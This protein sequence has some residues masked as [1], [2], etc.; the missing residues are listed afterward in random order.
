MQPG[1]VRLP[2]FP[3]HTVLFPG[4]PLPLRIFESRYLEM[5]SRCLKTDCGFGVCLISSGSEVGGAAQTYPLGTVARITDWHRRHDGLLGVTAVGERRF[6]ISSV[7]REPNQLAVAEVELLADEAAVELPGPY[8]GLAQLLGELLDK[9][10]HHYAALPRRFADASW[11]GF[12][13]AELLP[14]SLSLKQ[15]LLELTDPLERLQQ[16]RGLLEGVDIL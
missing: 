9:A 16:L 10:G 13:L 11:V 2:L 6:R 5:V 1:M 8:L 14:V 3:L 15:H 4:G 12:R 7:A